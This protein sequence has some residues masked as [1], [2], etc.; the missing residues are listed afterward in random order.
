MQQDT[1]QSVF[2]T[3]SRTD[4]APRRHGE[5]SYAFLNRSASRYFLEVRALIED[6]YAHVP[7]GH[8]ASL[9]GGLTGEDAAFRS[10]FWEL[11]LHEAYRRSGYGVEIHPRVPAGGRRPDF[12]LTRGEEKFY[13]EAVSVGQDPS[14]VAENERLSQVYR[15]LSKMTIQDFFLGLD[16]FTIGARPLNT[17]HLR[18]AI[19]RWL[20]TLEVGPIA[21][22][23]A[24]DAPAL[25]VLPELPWHEDGW[26]LLITA[27]PLAEHARGA[28]RRALGMFGPGRASGVDNIT[29]I[30]RV[31]DAKVDRYGLLDAPLVIAVQSS[32]EFPTRD[33]EFESALYGL[34]TE[35]PPKAG[36]PE[37]HLAHDGLWVG[38]LGWRNAHV[39]QVIT[40]SDLSPW[41]AGRARPRVWNTYQSG[42]ARPAQPEW[43]APVSNTGPDPHPG[44]A[45]SMRTHFGLPE[46]WP[47]AGEPDFSD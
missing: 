12:R 8:R 24:V 38:P 35:R 37:N 39:P 18:A 16:V 6:W 3:I 17:R 4:A 7:P 26:H 20:A 34:G 29:G 43:L 1:G 30:R 22:R 25:P 28:D 23:A 42:V 40:T 45:L 33:Y 15:V 32:T 10:A 9:R 13:L 21:A 5:S 14:H 41:T 27:W 11:Y 2:D 46:D 44:P 36:D 47:A 19:R 31:L